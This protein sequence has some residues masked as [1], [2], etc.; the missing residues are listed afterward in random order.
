MIQWGIT[1]LI[2]HRRSLKTCLTDAARFGYDWIELNCVRDYYAHWNAFQLADSPDELARLNGLLAECRLGCSAVDCHGLFGRNLEEFNYTCDYLIAG[3]RI[4]Q[5][6]KSPVVI[7]S[8]PRGP[9][10]WELMVRTTA[11]LCRKAEDAGLTLAIEAEYDFTVGTPEE[12]TNFLDA[13]DRPNLKVNFDPSHF[14]R[15]GFDVPAMVRRF[16]EKIVHVHLK[17]FLP[18][19]PCIT[20]YT[21]VEASPCSR[22]LDELEFLG[23]NGVASAETLVDLGKETEN[24]AAEIMKG[25][26]TWETRKAQAS[27]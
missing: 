16:F 10:P 8:I 3:F 5:T 25:I 9:A 21:G 13:V 6:L 26:K 18:H 20:R 17:E 7:T 1:T 23:Y 12:L 4:A 2:G 22:M 15:A 24:P 27:A 11:E 14:A 19:Q